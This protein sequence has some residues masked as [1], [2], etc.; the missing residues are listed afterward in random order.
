MR[1]DPVDFLYELI[2]I[3]SPSRKE[4]RAARLVV[5]TMK[6]LGFK[7]A[8]ID[9]AGNAVCTNGRRGEL[10]LLLFSHMD[11]IAKQIP[12]KIEN[13]FIHG[14][15]AA[16]AKSSLAA[17]LFAAANVDVDYKL[18]LAGVVE[19]ETTTSKGIKHILKYAKPKLAMLGEPSNTSGIT[20]AY[21][22]RVLIDGIA[23]GEEMHASSKNN[24]AFSSFINFSNRLNV[25]CRKLDSLTANITYAQYGSRD[26]LNVIPG[27]LEF[28]VDCRFPTKFHANEI[29]EKIKSLADDPVKLK[30]LDSINGVEIDQN[31]VLVRGFISAIRKVG[32]APRY[33]KKAGSSDMNITMIHGIPTVAY[34]P[35]DS[36][37]S[38]TNHE[39]VAIDEYIKAIEI[40]ENVLIRL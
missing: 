29:F 39:K 38:H 14:R 28:F 20:I 15:G 23:S 31:H 40:I 17:L 13:H 34:G 26:A 16:D 35:G 7:D 25:F 33:V 37:L 6:K 9:E 24:N 8:H 12:C 22:G 18:M 11:T 10:E 19:E 27:K 1:V 30:L 36:S 2:K 3:P 32:L 21:R 4:G 5:K